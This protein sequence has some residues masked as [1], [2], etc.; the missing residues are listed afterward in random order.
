MHLLF[1]NIASYMLQFWLGKFFSN[2]RIQDN[3]DYILSQS[4]WT[5]IGKEME[6]IQKMIPTYF[7]RSPRNIVLH[8]NGYKAKEWEA[9]ITL[10]SLPLLKGRML[11]KHYQ[12]W[13]YFVKAVRLC[14]KSTLTS[15]ELDNIQLLFRSF[16]DYYET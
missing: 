11:E 10:Y 13:A 4:Q 12:G 2:K 8:Y 3:G 14:Q 7:G 9:W 6:N 1:E 16:Y 5:E 15:Q